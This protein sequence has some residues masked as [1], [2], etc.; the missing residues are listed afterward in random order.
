MIKFYHNLLHKCLHFLEAE[1][2]MLQKKSST[3][4][5]YLYKIILTSCIGQHPHCPDACLQHVLPEGHSWVLSHLTFSAVIAGCFSNQSI[6]MFPWVHFPCPTSQVV[7]DGQQ[8]TWSLQHTAWREN[9]TNINKWLETVIANSS[10]FSNIIKLNQWTAGCIVDYILLCS[11]IETGTTQL[12]NS[13]RKQ[14]WQN[15]LFTI[16]NTWRLWISESLKLSDKCIDKRWIPK[17]NKIHHIS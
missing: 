7:P 11:Y 8:W 10:S 16:F 2:I 12:R 9:I 13:C 1:I 15:P 5:A 17:I 3:I 14:H 6:C 4:I